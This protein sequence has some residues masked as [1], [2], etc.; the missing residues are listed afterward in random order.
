MC[1]AFLQLPGALD[2]KTFVN[3]KTIEEVA[4][5]DRQGKFP[6]ILKNPVYKD[7]IAVQNMGG[8]SILRFKADNP[9]ILNTE[10]KRWNVY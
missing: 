1:D 9:G 5:M 4:E 8:Y 3:D 10:V 7:T 6:R 2:D